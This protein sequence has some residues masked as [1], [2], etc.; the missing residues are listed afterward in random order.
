MENTDKE[1]KYMRARERVDEL[2]KFYGN[3]TSYVLVISGL[4]LINYFTTGFGYMWFLWA[5]FGWGIGI[6]FH[7]I[8]TFDL[9]PFFGKQWEKRKIEKIM[10]DEEQNN[11]WK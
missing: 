8:K 5:A 2:K 1:N 4:A 10:R 9:N 6:V 11:K 3:L 7:A